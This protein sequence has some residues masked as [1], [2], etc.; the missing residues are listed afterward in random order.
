M[1]VML[2][3]ESSPS[4]SNLED[5]EA[6]RPNCE[7]MV[8]LA[9]LHISVVVSTHLVSI[10]IPASY[11]CWVVYAQISLAFHDDCGCQMDQAHAF[12]VD[13]VDLDKAILSSQQLQS[14]SV[15]SVS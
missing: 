14:D 8:L 2:Q 9:Y 7:D 10:T 13:D 15:T 12:D 11:S 1:M 4:C 6:W 3:I 5:C